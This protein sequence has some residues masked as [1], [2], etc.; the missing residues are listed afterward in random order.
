MNEKFK[1]IQCHRVA[2]PPVILHDKL[3]KHSVDILGKFFVGIFFLFIAQEIIPETVSLA[4]PTTVADVI[5]HFE[6]DATPEM[7]AM[8]PKIPVCV[9]IYALLFNGVFNMGEALYCL[10]V[11]RSRQVDYRALWEGFGLYFKAL[12]MFVAQTLIVAF[13]SMFFLIP[14]LIALIN[15][16]QSFFIL[17]DNPEKN[18]FECMLESKIRMRGNRKMYIVYIISF[19]PYILL[20]MIIPVAAQMLFS[21]DTSTVEGDF[22][23]LGL[24]APFYMAIGYWNLGKTV[25]YELLMTGGFENFKYKDQDVF[26]QPYDMSNINRGE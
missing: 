13:W 18:I 25:F 19:L 9:Y 22:I 12:A 6:P 11:I 2:V 24:N 15:F 17:A 8:L 14:G 23:M 10:T 3:R 7:I 4:F 16:S 1:L 20:G 5:A 26:R 21:I